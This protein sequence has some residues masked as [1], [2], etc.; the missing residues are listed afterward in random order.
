MDAWL[1]TNSYNANNNL[2]SKFGQNWNGSAWV[3]YSLT[4]Y[5][6][7]AS[8]ILTG[9][10]QQTWNGSAWV[11]HFQWS[12]TYDANN[13]MVSVFEQKWN[14]NAWVNHLNDNLTY[15]ANNF[16]E[17]DSYKFWNN[18]GTNIVSGDSTYYYFHTVV[19]VNELM[20]SLK[21]VIIYPN[22]TSGISTIE[23]TTNGYLSIYNSSGQ[24]LLQQEI[25]ESKTII[26]I[27]TL[28]SG[29]YLIKLINNKT[30]RV[31]KLILE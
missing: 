6:Y 31:G 29:V 30:V 2:T 5:A 12:F 23:T 14:G 26:D 16:T 24:E 17:S 3:N 15:D 10:L 11:N 18:Y 25:S 9:D 4:T 27:S 28:P 13:N 19:G 1:T 22:P 8:N 20:M 7:D 21:S